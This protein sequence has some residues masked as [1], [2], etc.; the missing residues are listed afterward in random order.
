MAPIE[1]PTADGAKFHL[2]WGRVSVAAGGAAFFLYVT[3][4]CAAFLFIRY[5]RGVETVSFVDLCLPTRWPHYRVALG[6]SQVVHAQSLAA[7][8]HRREAL[9]LVHAGVTHSPASRDG[10]LLLAQLFAEA[11]RIDLTLQTLTE[12][13]QFHRDDPVFLHAMFTALLFQQQDARVI[14]LARTLLPRQPA[15][16][17]RDR[18]VALA[19][20]TGSYFRGNFDQA[21]DFLNLVP[22][23]ANSRDGRLLAAKIDWTRGYRELAVISL[24]ALATERPNDNEVHSELVHRL[25]ESGLRDEARRHSLAFQ[26]A[27]PGLPGPRIELLRDLHGSGTSERATREADALLRDFATDPT[28]LL[29]LADFAANTGD[30]GLARRLLDHAQA[31]DLPWEPHALLHIEALI[32]ARDFHGALDTA[33]SLL[34]AHQDFS[35]RFQPVLNSLRAIAHFGL[36][37]FDSA[38]LFLTN[39]LNQSY[40]RAENLLAIAQRLTEV[41]AAVPARET[42]VRAIAVD[43]L[44]QA[45]LARLIELDLNL[46]RI[47]ELPAHLTRFVAMRQP[48]PDILRVAHHKLGSDLFLFSAE[49]PAALTAVREALDRKSPQRS[50]L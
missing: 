35:T 48:S 47:D 15:P 9:G 10:R 29:A 32:A 44:N 39:Y 50:R 27:H 2:R 24:R 30:P 5:R 22:T 8:G 37:E 41:D 3:L 33:D 46:N 25:R 14:A 42:L 18:L 36:G 34:R 49:R 21:E 1:A 6:D 19:A 31:H 28:A 26:I 20:A 7:S 45:A 11:G 12:G 17:E 43:P 16:T 23:L 4:V 38:R 13:L 40:L